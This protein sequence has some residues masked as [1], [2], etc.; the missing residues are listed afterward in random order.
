MAGMALQCL[1]AH[2][3]TPHCVMQCYRRHP[4]GKGLL[5]CAQQ[6]DASAH[7]DPAWQTWLQEAGQEVHLALA[8]PAGRRLAC[9]HSPFKLLRSAYVGAHLSA[10]VHAT[11]L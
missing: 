6:R 8:F 3:L 7:I 9:M 11:S 10:Y 5:A 1:A 2:V 4:Q